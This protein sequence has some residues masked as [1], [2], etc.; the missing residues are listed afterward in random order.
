[1]VSIVLLSHSNE[2]I[3]NFIEFCEVL[4]QDDFKILNGA[5]KKYAKFGT[6]KEQVYEV[7]K[8]ANEGQGV[9]ALVDFGS[10]ID[11]L[12]E[13]KKLV[14]N[15]FQVEIADCPIIEGAISAVGANDSFTSLE[16]LKLIAEDSKNFKKLR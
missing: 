5:G 6:T 1:M 7:L 11:V 15:E 13:A 10:S 9:L 8:E 2:M 16:Q 4:K 14:N 3:D 12:L